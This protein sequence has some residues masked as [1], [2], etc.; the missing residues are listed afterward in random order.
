MKKRFKKIIQ[1]SLSPLGY[2]IQRLPPHGGFDPTTPLP[3]DAVQE[4]RPDHP[5][6][7]ELERRYRSF[8][9][10]VCNHTQWKGALRNEVEDLQYFR[11][12]N[13][14]VWAYRSMGDAR[15]RYYIYGQYVQ[16]RDPRGLL[17]RVLAEDGSLGCFS[18]SYQEMPT[19]SRDLLDSVNELYFLD[20]HCQVLDRKGLRV[21][22]VGA[23]YGRLAYRMLTA[24]P[25]VE[26]Y[27][28]IDAIPRSTFVSEYYLRYRGL[29][30]QK[31][32][33][34]VVVPLYEMENSPPV[35]SID[36]AINI[37]SFSEMCYAAI[38]GWIN[39]LGKLQVPQLFL[40]PNHPQLLSIEADGTQRDFSDVLARNGYR[41]VAHEPVIQDADV[42][43]FIEQADYFWLFQRS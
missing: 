40:I 10:P 3:P 42:R 31:D 27:W 14:Y 7:L 11:G 2:R 22:D 32:S 1:K 15:R 18:Y 4:L 21:L 23:G 16:A 8:D 9:S 28:C 19:L 43:G 26:R 35:G 37:H 29:A 34:A 30:G 20:R 39:W 38:E 36:L 25:G 12:D 5:R 41:R 6:L 17:G 33:R 24:A 13:A